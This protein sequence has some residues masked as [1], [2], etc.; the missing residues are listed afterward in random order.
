MVTPT[1][2]RT[3]A[4]ARE[5][6]ASLGSKLLKALALLVELQ[7]PLFIVPVE[8]IETVPPDSVNVIVT[9]AKAPPA[10]NNPLNTNKTVKKRFTQTSAEKIIKSTYTIIP[11]Q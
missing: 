11:K 8:L 3:E 7:R 9:A 2:S 6:D 10:T 5:I 4:P 1:Q